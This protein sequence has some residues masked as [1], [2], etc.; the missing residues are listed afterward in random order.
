M[1]KENIII[2]KIYL[3]NMIFHKDAIKNDDFIIDFI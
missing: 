3:Y 1:F 2:C